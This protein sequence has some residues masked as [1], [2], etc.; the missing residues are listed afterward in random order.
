MKKLIFS[1]AAAAFILTS[2]DPTPEATQVKGEEAK[3]VETNTAAATV[4]KVDA[5]GSKI[6]WLGSKPTGDSHNGTINLTGGELTI[7]ANKVLNGGKFVIDMNTIKVL[8]VTDPQKNAG[9]V[10]HLSGTGDDAAK[11]DDFFNVKKYP[12]GEFAITGVKEATEADKANLKEATHMIT[13]NLTLKGITKSISFPAK[14][15]VSEKGVEAYSEMNF[16]RTEWNIKFNSDEM[17]K[18]KFINKNI[19][20]K[21]TIK[22]AV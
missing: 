12:T 18:D 17:I 19:N 22:A 1:M 15:T 13:G 16:D 3:Q 10:A 11:A 7:D 8:D 9:L 2:C 4:Y 21:L 20:L 6:E 14:V 5:A